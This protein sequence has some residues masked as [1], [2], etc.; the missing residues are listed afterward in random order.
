MSEDNKSLKK[1]DFASLDI[2]AYIWE[3]RMP[4]AI[5][6]IIAAIISL[7]I[8]FTIT[9]VFK[10]SLVIFPTSNGFF[11]TLDEEAQAEQLLQVIISEEV[12]NRVIAKNSLMAHYGIDPKSDF[13]LTKLND[14]Y[15]SNVKV[16]KTQYGSIQVDVMDKDPQMAADIA[17]DISAL[18]DTVYNEIL[19]KKAIE[20][21]HN[22]ERE[23]AHFLEGYNAIKDSLDIIRSYGINDYSSQSERYHESY[24]KALASGDKNAMKALDEKLKLLSKYG[25]TY[26]AL[27][28]QL[29]AAAK[30]FILQKERFRLS[31]V[32]TEQSYPH[33]F[34]VNTA[35]KPEKKAYPKKSIIVIIST[36]SAFFMSLMILMINENLKARRL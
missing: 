4:L 22:V 24:A 19:R 15:S 33:Q 21:F 20:V 32:D 28:N 23:Y 27:D 31:K 11:T 3:K 18:T 6:T 29:K 17:N 5:I 14:Y 9:P 34:V 8:S 10:S 2:L 35:A 25:G 16:R 30:T 12:K 36:L 7:L 13:P 1:Y 26:E